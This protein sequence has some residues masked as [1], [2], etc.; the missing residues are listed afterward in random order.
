MV[1]YLFEQHDDLVSDLNATL[2]PQNF[3]TIIEMQP[4]PTYFVEH[5]IQKGGNVL[6][7]DQNLHNRL[8]FS[9]GATLLTPDSVKQLPLVYQKVAAASRRVEVFAQ[10]VG[11]GE[12][13]QYLP[14]ADASQNPL[15]SYGAANVQFLKQVAK[16][17][18]PDGFFQRMVP[19]GFKIDRVD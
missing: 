3:S 14:Y 11:S 16:A 18:D 17:Y 7:L 5:G 13:F 8:Y 19:G 15:G 6:G 12:K 10:S 2:G 4:L 9:L 1:H